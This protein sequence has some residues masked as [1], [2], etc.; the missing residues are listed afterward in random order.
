M[1]PA[2]RITVDSIKWVGAEVAVEPKWGQKVPWVHPK[3]G[4]TQH[5][6]KLAPPFSVFIQFSII[7]FNKILNKKK[8][9]ERGREVMRWNG[10]HHL[11]R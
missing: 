11:P 8:E 10:S 2:V 6:R 9:R 1:K 3:C 7:I 4:E 5:F